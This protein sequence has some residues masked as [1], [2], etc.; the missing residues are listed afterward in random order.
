MLVGFHALLPASACLITDNVSLA[1]GKDRVFPR[2]SAWLAAVFGALPDL[3]NPHLTLE[4]RFTS[5]SHTVWFLGGLVVF[6]AMVSAYFEKGQRLR[7]AIVCWIASALH[8][9]GDAA[10]GGIAWLYPWRD[11]VIGLYLIPPDLWIWFDAFFI[12]LTWLL[13]RVLPHLE[14]RGIRK[15]IGDVKHR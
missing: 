8:L 14:A 12:I 2:R 5:W 9:A 13:V 10:S 3:C 4:A 1:L 7:V 6:T 11:E 15:V